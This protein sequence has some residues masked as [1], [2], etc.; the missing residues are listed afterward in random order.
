MPFTLQMATVHMYIYLICIENSSLV[1]LAFLVYSL[2][3]WGGISMGT[4]TYLNYVPFGD[5]PDLGHT[6]MKVHQAGVSIQFDSPNIIS[7]L[8][9]HTTM[10]SVSDPLTYTTLYCTNCRWIHQILRL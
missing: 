8:V 6:S 9:L 10:T 1:S 4:S 3:F 5:I 7:S 2:M